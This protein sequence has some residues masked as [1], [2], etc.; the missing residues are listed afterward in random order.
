M[1]MGG[2]AVSAVRVENRGIDPQ[3]FSFLCERWSV[4]AHRALAADLAYL[5]P[6]Q[7]G[8]LMKSCHHYSTVRGRLHGGIIS[9]VL[10]TAMGWALLSLG[11]SPITTD[12]YTNYLATV[13]ADTALT[14]EAEVV[15]LG[16][17]TAVAQGTLRDD[18]GR[19][20][21]TSRGTFAIKEIKPRMEL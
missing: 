10:D 9:A 11:Y 6:G 17:R 13:F 19:L 21:A 20:V 15:H 18:Q 4:P 12:M 14:A 16:N 1:E 5:G 2:W 8:V 7:A 3:F